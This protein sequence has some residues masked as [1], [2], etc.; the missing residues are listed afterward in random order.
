MKTG[1]ERITEERTRQITHEGWSQTHDAEH[2][3]GVLCAAGTC[4]EIVADIQAQHG[5]CRVAMPKT[6]PW[7]E[8]WWKPAT[9]AARNY[10]KAGAL[11]K[12]E[13]DRYRWFRDFHNARLW[14]IEA[15]RIGR[16]IDGLSDTLLVVKG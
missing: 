14:D 8:R 13:A 3:A 1:I 11:F 4:Y 15:E 9:N 16:K 10:E 7:E 5:E 6:W 2:S 12:A